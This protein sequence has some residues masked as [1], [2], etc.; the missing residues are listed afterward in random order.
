MLAF[1]EREGATWGK[2]QVQG[3]ADEVHTV[4]GSRLWLSHPA[5]IRVLSLARD[6]IHCQILEKTESKMR[7]KSVKILRLGLGGR[8]PKPAVKMNVKPT[9]LS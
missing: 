6:G 2:D 9:F 5:R 7:L 4:A 1:E 3:P 8:F